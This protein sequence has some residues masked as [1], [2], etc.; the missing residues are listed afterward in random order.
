MKDFACI[1]F[2]TLLGLPAL[3]QDAVSA[4]GAID[5]AFT[6]SAIDLASIP[7]PDGGTTSVAEA[8]LVLTSNNGGPIDRLAGTCLLQGLTRG[9]DWQ[10]SGSC[11]LADAEGD[12]LFETIEE[13]G[14]KGHAVLTGGTGKFAGISGE[15][16]YTTTWFSSVR[17]GEN[18]G[19]GVKKGHWRRTAM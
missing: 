5:V 19:V 12:F 15:H 2:A 17:A 4:E 3:A 13:T 18:Q 7:A 14:D 11:T 6:W 8:H 10:S 1:A 16:D 9:Q